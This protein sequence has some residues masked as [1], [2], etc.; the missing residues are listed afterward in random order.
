MTQWSY[1]KGSWMNETVLN[2]MLDHFPDQLVCPNRAWEPMTAGKVMEGEAG[3]VLA[4]SA[5]AHVDWRW[6]QSCWLGRTQ[7]LLKSENGSFLICTW[8][9]TM[10]SALW[11]QPVVGLCCVSLVDA[12]YRKSATLS[13]STYIAGG[14]HQAQAHKEDVLTQKEAVKCLRNSCFIDTFYSLLIYTP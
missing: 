6:P 9:L 7:T 13:P 12:L 14:T 11:Y 1:V 3:L 5:W 10:P 2:P 8:L 4:A